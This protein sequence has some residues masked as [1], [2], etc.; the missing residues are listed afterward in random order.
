MIGTNVDGTPEIIK[1]GYNGILIEPKNSKQIP[2]AILRL[3]NNKEEIKK[4]EY[5][6]FQ[7][8]NNLFNLEKFNDKYVKFYLRIINKS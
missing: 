4:Y 5:N 7:T 6:A 1:A 3:F 2:Q 8:F